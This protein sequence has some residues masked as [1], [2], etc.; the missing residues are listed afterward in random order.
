MAKKNKERYPHFRKYKRSG[1][2]ALIIGEYPL[3]RKEYIYRKVM[4]NTHDGRHLNERVYPNPDPTDKEPMYIAK[5]KRHDLKTN[6]SRWKYPWRY[7][8]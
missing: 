4:H 2:P 7:K 6:F 3:N 5:R 1:H 8:K